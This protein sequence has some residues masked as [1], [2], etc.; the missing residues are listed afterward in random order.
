VPGE[1]WASLLLASLGEIGETPWMAII[2]VFCIIG[3]VII[4]IREWELAQKKKKQI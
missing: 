1:G 2:V 4:G 3:L